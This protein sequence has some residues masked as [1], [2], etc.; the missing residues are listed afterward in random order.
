MRGS[1]GWARRS[2]RPSRRPRSELPQG[3]RVL[4]HEAHDAA[5]VPERAPREKA[6]VGHGLV[7]VD[8]DRAGDVPALPAGLL[9]PVG[10]VDVLAV[11]VVALVE[12]AELLE[13]LPSKE[14]ER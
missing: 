9:R 6:A 11:E 1:P 3:L 14:E 4:A 2:R 5:P 12:P 7:V 10:E 13:Q 8:D